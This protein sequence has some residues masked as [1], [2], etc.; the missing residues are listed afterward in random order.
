[1]TADKNVRFEPPPDGMKLTSE[2]QDGGRVQLGTCG[3]YWPE[4]A[5]RGTWE[6]H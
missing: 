4:T 3:M 1:M 2:N 6:V 5:I